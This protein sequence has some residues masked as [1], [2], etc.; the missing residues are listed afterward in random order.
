VLWYLGYPD[1]SFV[2]INEALTQA[3]E[4]S[5]PYSQAF[6][7][8]F[9]A[10]IYQLRRDVQQVQELTEELI[11]LSSE[12]GF[13]QWLPYGTILKG[14]LLSEQQQGEKGLEHI[15]K[16]LTDW[17]AAGAEISLPHHLG[18]LAETYLKEKRVEDGLNSI[19]EALTVV[20]KNGERY[21]EAELYR[22]KGE[23]LIEFYGKDKSDPEKSFLK[24]IDI[25]RKQ[26]AKSLELRAVTSYSRLLQTQGKKEEA[27]QMLAEI[28]SWFTEGFETKDLREAKNFLEE[29][30]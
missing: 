14:Y 19:A 8:Y 11:A 26:K 16:G 20:D 18:L 3:Q 12:N 5:H 29:L 23:L 6:A 4:L 27:R 30:S 24:S 28:Y 25:A 1:Q 10:T 7:L 17:R 9:A 21:Y 22:L 2:K 15:R 13:S